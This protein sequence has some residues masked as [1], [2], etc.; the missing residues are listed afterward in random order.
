M[1]RLL[2]NWPLKLT[3][4]LL[5]IGLWSHVRGASN[6]LETATF[7]VNLDARA[8]KNLRVVSSDAPKTVR[9]T[10]RAPH[11]ELRAIGGVTL[12]LTNPLGTPD[13][14]AP[15]V[16]NGALVAVLDFSGVSPEAKTAQIVPV[17]V[18]SNAEEVE[19]LGVKPAS[20]KIVLGKP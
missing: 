16:L 20:A 11:L 10:V 7:S 4:I 3:A 19:I 13:A 14:D 15:P 18:E 1:N 5:S 12:P 8:P 17:R 9:V 2:N 6:P